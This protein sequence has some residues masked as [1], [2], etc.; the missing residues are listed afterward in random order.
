MQG[1]GSRGSRGGTEGKRGILDNH[2]ANMQLRGE[3]GHRGRGE[4]I[5]ISY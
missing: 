5:F 1:A 3:R 4:R 2:P